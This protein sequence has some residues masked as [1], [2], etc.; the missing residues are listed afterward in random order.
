MNSMRSVLE[1]IM[2]TLYV[3]THLVVLL[4]Q[5]LESMHT[6][7]CLLPEGTMEPRIPMRILSISKSV[8]YEL[9]IL[10]AYY[11]YAYYDISCFLIFSVGGQTP[12]RD[13]RNRRG[14]GGASAVILQPHITYASCS[15]CYAY[16]MNTMHRYY[17]QEQYYSPK[18]LW[19]LLCILVVVCIVEIPTMPYAYYYAYQSAI[20]VHHT[21]SSNRCAAIHSPTYMGVTLCVQHVCILQQP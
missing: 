11:L 20:G 7:S 1:S 8:Q 14:D 10:R 21:Y 17:L 19:I 13:P 15:S 6:V 3:H 16:C 12:A 2:D 4:L 5:Q 9:V 18:Q